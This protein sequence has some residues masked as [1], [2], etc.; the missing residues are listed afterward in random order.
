MALDRRERGERTFLA[1]CVAFPREGRAL[2]EEADLEQQFSSDLA[3]RAAAH[4]RAHLDAPLEG[5]PD[6]DPELATL[7]LRA[8]RPRRPRRRR[9]AP[10][11]SSTPGSRSSSPAS[12]ARSTSPATSGTADGSVSRLSTEREQVRT[13]LRLLSGKLQSEN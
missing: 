12:N 1:L 9:V 11:T 8:R 2:L 10:A 6:D 4:L 13:R 3:R 5:L 7:R